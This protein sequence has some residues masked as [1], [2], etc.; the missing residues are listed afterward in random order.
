MTAR[1]DF[2]EGDL[3]SLTKDET[4]VTGRLAPVPRF[5]DFSVGATG[6]HLLSRISAGWAATLLARKPASGLYI[7]TSSVLDSGLISHGA[8]IVKWKG[9]YWTNS[10]GSALEGHRLAE[11]Q[12]AFEAGKLIGPLK[13]VAAE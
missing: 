13:A 5:G 10:E 4:T 1:D 11:A 9:S 3:V 8:R 2:R 7:W 6:W 12:R